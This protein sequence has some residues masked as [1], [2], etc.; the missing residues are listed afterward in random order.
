MP[1][2]I[3]TFSNRRGGNAFYKA[4]GHP[5]AGPGARA[6]IE[7]LAA[8]GPV[9]IYDPEGFAEGFDALYPLADLEIEGIYVQALEDLDTPVLG[10]RVRPVTDLAGSAAKQVFVLA[11]D[12]ERPVSHMRHLVPDGAAIVTL[13]EMRIP[14]AMLTNRRRYLDTLNFATN[15]AFFRDELNGNGGHHTRIVTANYWGG[16]GAKDVKVFARLYDAA[17]DVLAE[18]EEALGGP[19]ASVVIDSAEV[20]ARFGLGDFAGQLFLHVINVAGHDIV[21][22]ALDTYGDNADILSC[23]H[24]ANAWPADL[25][26]GLPA[27]KD[28]ERV[29]LWV[30]NSHPEPIPAGEIGLN[31]M[32]DDRIVSHGKDIS[33]FGSEVIDVEALLPGVT[34]PAQIEVQAGKHM[35]RPR[36][37]VIEKSSGRHRIAHVNVERTDLKPDPKIA[38][39]SNLMGKGYLLPA[40]VLPPDRYVTSALPTPMATCQQNL[41]VALVLYDASGKEVARHAFG[42]LDRSDSVAVEANDILNGHALESGYG[43]MELLYD[44]SD[45][46]EADGWL[47]GL[48]RFE[49]KTTGHGAETSFGAHIFN[50]VLTYNNEPQSYAGPAPGLSTRLFLR[51]GGGIE[52][53]GKAADAFCHLIYPASTPWH[54]ASSTQLILTSGEGKEIATRDIAIPCGGSH[55]WRLSETFEA[56]EIENAGPHGYVI[57]RDVTC[58]LFGYHGLRHGDNGFSLDHMFGF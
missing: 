44:F 55:H 57:I 16:Y 56:G 37:E 2:N 30:Q 31:L 11:F 24:D 27:P 23:T 41:P 50:A 29:V 25:Y 17:G 34:W 33:A 21:K 1:L 10:Q 8:G 7:K 26:A 53:E 35:V 49:D 52:A 38:E 15:F 20:R 32:G 51:T 40:P 18:W 28:G 46:G 54:P 5:L 13:D 22:Y 48:F 19:Y 6:L 3:N 4:I 12:A 9:A 47:H 58:R 14:D 42:K 43:H 45:G 39:L 36:Y